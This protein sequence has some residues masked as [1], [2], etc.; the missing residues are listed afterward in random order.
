MNNDQE[1]SP[2]FE[3]LVSLDIFRGLIMFLLIAETAGVYQ[4]LRKLSSEESFW[5]ALVGQFHHHAWHGL[6]FWDLIQPYFM[7]IVGVAMA[8]SVAKRLASGAILRDLWRH[9]IFRCALLLLFG[10][11]LHCIYAGEL[12]WELWNVLSQLSVTILI[13]F[14]IMRLPA[15]AQIGIAFGLI[16]ATEL[17]YR[18]CS[19]E[20]Y[21]QPFVLGKNFG[22]WVDSILM[23]RTR[24]FPNTGGWVAINCI[25]TAAHTIWGV[26][27]GQ[28][29][30]GSRSAA[31]K[32]AIL[33]VCG[34]AL[35]AG[36]Y[37]LDYFD[38]T[39]IIKRICTSSFVIT[40]GGWCLV[41]LALLYWLVDVVELRRWGFP[42]LVVG[43]N[44]IFIYLFSRTIGGQWFN[45][46]V[47]IFTEGFLKPLGIPVGTLHVV[48]ALTVLALEWWLCY[49]LY[50]RKILIKI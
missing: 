29:L 24:E 2:V 44:P 22:T 49:W 48:T 50:R 19:I 16:L 1:K 11:G 42:F 18:F 47:A 14:A 45:K 32:I 10:V 40:S 39:P 7:F 43:V 17:A 23:P 8:F 46:T 25:P 27:A 12:R 26:V 3:R 4:T 38:I 34:A 5:G 36:G 41:T 37:A 33:L 28:L 15:I 31:A 6:H 30:L 35:L 21:D 13:A 9:I 20:G